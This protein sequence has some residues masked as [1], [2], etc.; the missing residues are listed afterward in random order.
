M[1]RDK[2]TLALPSCRECG[3]CCIAPAQQGSFCDVTEQDKK[4]LGKKFVRLHV[5]GSSFIERFSDM[6]CGAP[7]RPDAID[8]RWRVMSAGP[9]ATYEFNTCSMLR[10]S[11][12][13]RVS[14]R[15]YDKRPRAC[16]VAVEPGDATCLALREQFLKKIED[17]KTE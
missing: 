8:T 6:F 11:V 17:L 7:H 2:G 13:K 16:R 3:A 10:G 14:C 4:R 9:L 15:I 5:I 12:M 1:H